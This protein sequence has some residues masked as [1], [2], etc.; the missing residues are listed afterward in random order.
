MSTRCL[1]WDTKLKA[2]FFK[3]IKARHINLKKTDKAYILSICDRYCRPD[4]TFIKNYNAS[5]AEWRIG[6][7]VNK[8]HKG[9]GDDIV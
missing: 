9:K 4:P 7:C 6:H 3:H 1:K 5:V 2:E 8:Y